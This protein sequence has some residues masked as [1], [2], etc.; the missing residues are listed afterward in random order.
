MPGPHPLH[1]GHAE[2]RVNG[3]LRHRDDRAGCRRER[4]HFQLERYCGC[5]ESSTFHGY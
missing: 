2:P 3:L 5:C 4:A 1:L